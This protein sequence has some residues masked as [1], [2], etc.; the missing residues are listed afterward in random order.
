MLI[1]T[2]LIAILLAAWPLSVHAEQTKEE[3]KLQTR[4]TVVMETSMGKIRIE[5]FVEEAPITTAN[6]RRYV[7]ESFYD[8]LILHRV[9][10][11][12][13]IQG[14]GF[15]P[16]MERRP[17]THPPIENEAASGMTNKRGTLSMARTNNINSATSQFFINLKDNATLDHRGESPARFGYA[18]FG[19]VIEGMEVVDT[20]AATATTSVGRYRNVP[21]KDIVIIKSYEE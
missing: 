19:R 5:L 18:V 10:R 13:V 8:G 17:P 7:K 16:G 21:E 2:V 9:M 15:L 4:P 20:I 14:G 6:F 3:T 12:F 1:R 11:T